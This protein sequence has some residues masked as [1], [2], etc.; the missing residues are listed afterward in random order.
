MPPP[1][2]ERTKIRNLVKRLLE[3]INSELSPQIWRTHPEVHDVW[4]S[5]E[6]ATRY[7][8]LSVV[9]TDENYDLETHDSITTNCTMK[10]IGFSRD[11]NDCRGALDAL[12]E[13]VIVCLSFSE[14]LRGAL[15]LL[16]LDETICDEGSSVAKPFAQFVMS[17]SIT[18]SR[19]FSYSS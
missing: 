16:N 4:I 10:I 3:E 14:E 7:P 11:E 2:S 18:F 6:N 9:L 1:I 17:W 13:D 12:I 8:A 5:Q 19:K 15:Q